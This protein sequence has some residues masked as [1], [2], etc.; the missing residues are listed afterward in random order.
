MDMLTTITITIGKKKKLFKFNHYY[1]YIGI[2]LSFSIVPDPGLALR[3][4]LK[5]VLKIQIPNLDLLLELIDQQENHLKKKCYGLPEIIW[6]II[7]WM[8]V[9]MILSKVQKT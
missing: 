2:H 4:A 5:P 3:Q 7:I 9:M 8:I 1:N 6:K